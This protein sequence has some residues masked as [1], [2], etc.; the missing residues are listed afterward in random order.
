[1]LLTHYQAHNLVELAKCADQVGD[2]HLLSTQMFEHQHHK[3]K[4]MEDVFVFCL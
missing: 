2:L 4:E 1:M 3:A